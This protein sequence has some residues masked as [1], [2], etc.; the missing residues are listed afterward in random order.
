MFTT[1]HVCGNWVLSPSDGGMFG[2]PRQF[3]NGREVCKR[4]RGESMFLCACTLAVCGCRAAICSLD[5]LWKMRDISSITGLFLAPTVSNCNWCFHA[6]QFAAATCQYFLC[7]LK[8]LIVIK[9]IKWGGKKTGKFREAKQPI[10][11]NRSVWKQDE[12]LYSLLKELFRTEDCGGDN[13]AEN[14]F[15]THTAGSRFTERPWSL[16]LPPS[17]CH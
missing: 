13:A 6:F 16:L 5:I 8:I 2:F 17:V 14:F 7:P 11:Q 4:R 12:F 9:R 15:L 10:Y 1:V 3:Q